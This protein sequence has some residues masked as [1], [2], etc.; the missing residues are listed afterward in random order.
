VATKNKQLKDMRANLAKHD[1]QAAADFKI[2][3]D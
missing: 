1:P 3:D 2:V